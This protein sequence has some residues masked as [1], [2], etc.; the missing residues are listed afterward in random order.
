M[1]ATA[2]ATLFALALTVFLV[3]LVPASWALRQAEARSGQRLAAFEERGTVWS[4]SARLR[5]GT[6]TGT[7]Q[8]E[9]VTWS[10]RP[11]SLLA[12]RLGFELTAQVGGAEARGALARGLDG[13][14]VTNLRA[15]AD[16]SALTHLVPL[17]AAWKP[18]GRI[19]L[20]APRMRLGERGLD[21]Q[22]EILW[23]DASLALAAVKPLGSY[24]LAITASDGPASLTLGT[25]SGPLRVSGSGTFAWPGT[26]SLSGEARAEGPQAA[27]LQ[28]VL[29]LLGPRRADGSH[30]LE[31][32]LR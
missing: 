27:Q 28:P 13:W 1:R 6:A 21:G 15:Q 4:G 11:A 16:A 29:D 24:R 19:D 12:A 18:E 3:A 14:H 20:I 22:G 26:F 23:R 9:R 30:A 31:L 5:I 8:V 10:F 7:V 17:L 2:L 32:K 25:V